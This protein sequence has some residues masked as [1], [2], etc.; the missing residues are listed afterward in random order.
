MCSLIRAITWQ[1][2]R[3]CSYLTALRAPRIVMEMQ[4]IGQATL[5]SSEWLAPVSHGPE[6]RERDV[7]GLRYR[8]TL[9][10]ESARP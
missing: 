8:L 7:P 4:K 9:R 5:P 3:S 6:A 1:L 10:R 2:A